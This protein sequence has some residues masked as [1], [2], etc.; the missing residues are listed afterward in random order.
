MVMMVP[1]NRTESAPL[2]GVRLTLLSNCDR[3]LVT[4]EFI[5]FKSNLSLVSIATDIIPPSHRLIFNTSNTNHQPSS[6]T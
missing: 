2:G 4:A 3:T 1:S 6:M 5:L